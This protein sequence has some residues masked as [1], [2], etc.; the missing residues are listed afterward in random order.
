MPSKSGWLNQLTTEFA[1]A[2]RRMKA[3]DHRYGLALLLCRLEP[4]LKGVN[5]LV[6]AA[7][8]MAYVRRTDKDN[9]EVILEAGK[10]YIG[11][12]GMLSDIQNGR[13]VAGTAKEIDELRSIAREVSV[14]AMQVRLAAKNASE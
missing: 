14:E 12:N 13:I 10:A 11:D 3:A 9:A 7:Q 4:D 5:E 2:E 1:D 8:S 6:V